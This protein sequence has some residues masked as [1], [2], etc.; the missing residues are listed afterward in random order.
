MLCYFPCYSTD[1]G[2]FGFS[3]GCDCGLEYL[4][5]MD[6]LS[7]QAWS[8]DDQATTV[9]TSH[10]LQSDVINLIYNGNYGCAEIPLNKI[11]IWRGAK[12]SLKV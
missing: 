5:T 10:Q 11:V 1:L 6:T 12:T 4:Y 3:Y 7:S 8:R 9:A 2:G